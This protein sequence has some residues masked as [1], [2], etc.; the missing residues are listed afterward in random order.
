MEGIVGHSRWRLAGMHV[1]A[2]PAAAFRVSAPSLR[3]AAIFFL[4]SPNFPSP[5]GEFKNNISVAIEHHC[6]DFAAM[7]IASI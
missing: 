1:F 6:I 2:D 3:S 7:E 5:Y 4:V